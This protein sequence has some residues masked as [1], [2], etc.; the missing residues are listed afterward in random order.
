MLHLIK[1]AVGIRDVAHLREVQRHRAA[2]NPPLRHQTRNAPR[3]VEEIL[4]GGSIYWVIKGFLAARQRIV[5]IG[6]DTWDDGSSCCALVLHP[7][8]VPVI[9]R[10]I[11]PFQGWRYLESSDAPQ[12]IPARRARGGEDA[13]PEALLR[14]LRA[15]CLI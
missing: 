6:Q 14:E 11:K 4:D 12:D 3:R 9:G 10:A 7:R 8:L 13:L 1:L 15:L 2:T 5:D